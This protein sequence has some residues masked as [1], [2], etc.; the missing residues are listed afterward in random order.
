LVG[1]GGD[2]V[3]AGDPDAA[4]QTFR[5]ARPS[6]LSAAASSWRRADGGP[7]RT[8]VLRTVHRHGPVLRAVAARVAERIGSAGVLAQRR[9]VSSP[10]ALTGSV[11]VR[12]LASAA[13]EA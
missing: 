8:V 5:G 10:S 13:A 3:L 2:V 7:A 12:V 1:E 9:A 6:F 4:T 11:A